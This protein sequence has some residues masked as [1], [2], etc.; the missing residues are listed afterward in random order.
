MSRFFCAGITMET[1]TQSEIIYDGQIISLRTG[2]ARLD[3]G[4]E[5]SREVVEHPGAVAVVPYAEGKVI[6]V[7]Q[8]RISVGQY[9]LEIPAGTMEGD[10]DPED[11]ARAELKEETGCTAGRMIPAGSFYPSP[12]VLSEKLHVFLALEIERGEQQLEEDENI[13]VVEMSIDEVRRHLRENLFEDGKSL[14]GLA[15]LLRYIDGGE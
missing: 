4:R 10:E 1:W 3:D 12:G 11:R 8:Y 13:E 14:I 7:R 2:S 15:A 5:V 9:L 6:L